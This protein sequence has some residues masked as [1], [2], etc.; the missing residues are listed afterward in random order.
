MKQLLADTDWLIRLEIE[1]RSGEDG[2]AVALAK[3]S[4]VH[5]NPISHAEFTSLGPSQPRQKALAMMHRTRNVDFQ[6]SQRAGDIR[7]LR[8]KQGKPLSTPDAFMAAMAIRYRFKLV[9][10]DKDLSGIPGLRW[11]AYARTPAQAARR[12]N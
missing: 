8:S 2:S 4:R 6:D 5:V 3:K 12:R 7:R 11:S 10:G 9:T 1:L